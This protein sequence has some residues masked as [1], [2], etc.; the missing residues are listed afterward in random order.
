MQ[1][2]QVEF[3]EE[4]DTQTP[5]LHITHKSGMS[6][7][8]EC[9]NRDTSNDKQSH[10]IWKQIERH[11]LQYLVER[12]LNYQIAFFARE[13]LRQAHVSFLKNLVIETIEHNFEPQ[14]LLRLPGAT[15]TLSDNA[16]KFDLTICKLSELDVK[17]DSDSFRLPISRDQTDFGT[18]TCENTE[19]D[20]G[21]TIIQNPRAIQFSYAN[22]VRVQSVKNTFKKAVKQLPITGLGVIYIRL[23]I[24]SWVTDLAETMKQIE[25][26]L[27][28]EL[29][30]KDNRRVNAV[31]V[32][33][34]YTELVESG[35]FHYPVY[36]PF[37]IVVEHTN[38]LK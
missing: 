17:L 28:K 37:R 8:V 31:I 34:Y 6:F 18:F 10:D 20:D 15:I 29:S 7:W 38:P 24:N 5:D 27:R 16:N 1:G 23:P 11:I 30:G 36:K 22:S 12:R 14:A 2:L 4:K 3:V 32:S 21:R 9:K 35:A 26:Y 33:I 13:E 19:L 25:Q